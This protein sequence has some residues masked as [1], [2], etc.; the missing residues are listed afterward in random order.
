MS[1]V[2]R[3]FAFFFFA[4]AFFFLDTGRRKK[5]F[6]FFF[7]F[8]FFLFETKSFPSR[9]EEIL[10][11]KLSE[12]SIAIETKVQE[13]DALKKGVCI[14]FLSSFPPPLPFLITFF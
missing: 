1:A 7:F 8:P 6:L 12:L 4:F 9:E 3:E 11:K 5:Y 2:S 13:I 14:F 10:A